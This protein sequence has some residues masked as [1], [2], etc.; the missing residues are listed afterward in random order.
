MSSVTSGNAQPT[1][2]DAT[3]ANRA[4]RLFEFLARAQEMKTARVRTF[5]GYASG[6]GSV[7]WLAEAPVHEAVIVAHRDDADDDDGR[8]V[9][10]VERVAKV[11]P[12]QPPSSLRG[13]VTSWAR[14]DDLP[15]IIHQPATR[16]PSSVDAYTTNEDVPGH[17][18][19]E[20]DLWLKSW[21]TWADQEQRDAPVRAY[22][23][24]LFSTHVQING[25]SEE[26][27]FVLGVGLLAW[28]PDQHVPVR[29]H[30]YTIPLRTEIDDSTGRLDVLID[31]AATGLTVEL[32]MLDPAVLPDRYTREK[33]EEQAE[34][35][36]RHPLERLEFRDLAAVL[37]NHIDSKGQYF[38]DSDR[39]PATGD[40]SITWAPALLVRPRRAFGLV[41]VLD[42]ISEKIED[43]GTVPEGLLPLVDPNHAPPVTTSTR[44][45][46]VLDLDGQ[47]FS[48]LPLN[49]VQRRILERVSTHAQTLVQGP[50]GTGKTHTAAALISHL[51]AQ[52]MRVLVT[53]HTDR[54]LHEVRGKLPDQV[55]PLA[56]SVIGSSRDDMADLKVAVDT[57]S[58]ESNEFEPEAARAGIAEALA[59]VDRLRQ[60]RQLLTH[61]LLRA[62]EVE[63]Q[64]H[65]HLGYEGTLAAIAQ[66][67]ESDAAS[68]GWIGGLAQPDGTSVSPLTDEEATRWLNLMRDDEV[69]AHEDESRRRLV[70]LDE[71]P[72]P[73]RFARD[74]A[75]YHE[76]SARCAAYDHLTGHP[77]R[78]AIH[79]LPA[80]TREAIQ[81]QLGELRQQ[82]D[83]LGRVR[84]Q[85][86]GDALHDVYAGQARPWLDRRQAVADRLR[87]T[88]E[89]IRFL[90]PGARVE[91]AGDP[92]PLLAMGDA[93]RAHIAS[94]GPLKVNVDG[95]PK[96]GVFASSVLKKAAPLFSQ[97]RVNG[98]PPTTPQAVDML[99]ANV[100]ASRLLDEL[101][102]A[103]PL[104]VVVPE[105][106]TLHERASWHQSQLEQLT[107]VLDLGAALR[108][109]EAHFDQ[110]GLPHPDWADLDS[111]RA[112]SDLVDAA[113]A[114]DSFD[115]VRAS[116]ESELAAVAD[117]AQ[118]ADVAAPV[119]ELHQAALLRDTEAFSAA[120]AKLIRLHEVK[121]L[122]DDR[123]QLTERIRQAAPDLVE[124]VQAPDRSSDW[125][126]RFERFDAA[127][128]W[129]S[130][131]TWILGREEID[132]N[133][134]QAKITV[135]EQ[136]LRQQAETIAATRAWTHAVSGERID[137]RARANLTQYSQLVKR[138]GKGTGKYAARQRADIREAMDRCRAAVPVWIMPIYRIAEQFKI[139]ENMF[140]VVIV[141]EASQA[142][143]EAAFLQFLAPKIV[144]IG[145]DKQ[146]SPSAVGIDQGEL[147]KLAEQYL[148]DHDH[149]AT[150]QDPKRSF[151]DEAVMR[152]GS[153][154]TLTE[155]R[156]C[157]PEIIGF[158]NRIAYE[159]DGVRLKPVRQFGADRLDPIKPVHLPRGYEETRSAR[160][161]NRAEAEALVEQIK[162]CATDPAYDG[163]TF[164]VIAL[165]GGGQVKLIESL[166]LDAI[167]PDEWGARD[168]RVGDAADFQGSERDVMFLSMVTAIGPN[169]RYT[170]LVKEDALQRFNVAAS[171]AK[172]QM[173][174]F[175][176]VGL[177]QLTNSQDLR[178]Q[179]V[180]YCYEIATRGIAKQGDSPAVP[181]DDRVAPFD[182][183]FE[184]RVYN[185]I[186]ERGYFV[187]PQYDANGYRIDL[188]VIGAH[189]RLAVECDG[190]HWHGPDAYLRDVSRQ[191]DLERCGWTFFRVR[192]S[193]YYLDQAG[194]LEGLWAMLHDLDIRP[195]GWQEVVDEPAPEELE[196][197]QP[198]VD[199][200]L[201]APQQEDEPT[202]ALDP[203]LVG[204]VLALPD[205]LDGVDEG[206]ARDADSPATGAVV[207]HLEVGQ[208]PARPNVDA[209]PE[210]RR[211]SPT[212]SGSLA[213][214]TIFDSTTTPVDETSARQLIDGLVSIVAVEGPILGERLRLSY[215][216]ASG[217]E[218]VGR[219]IAEDIDKA[220]SSA[221]RR[222]ELIADNPLKRPG[223]A[224]K[225]FRL[226]GQSWTVRELG[227]RTLAHVPPYE[228]AAVLR[229]AAA[230]R[231][232][233]SDTA[234]YRRAL[235]ILGRRQLTEQA[236][237]YLES[238][239]A[240]IDD[241][242]A[243]N[244][245]NAVGNVEEPLS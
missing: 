235:A 158:S 58:R 217:G 234:I 230:N 136:Q 191:R 68:F 74:V 35:Y 29:R 236:R 104:G 46:A 216:K 185:R 135:L 150:W 73:A 215:V 175:H 107:K 53:A 117:S 172:D 98:R 19:D 110:I 214:Y 111:V 228:A 77:A 232:H 165:L 145:D 114:S 188:V 20:Y 63:T 153:R 141:D 208:E 179:L 161:V 13:L 156:R 209:E 108:A 94:H 189:A 212:R 3:A 125:D 89:A 52:G 47:V 207:Q 67:F 112:Y 167:E 177:D 92:G 81:R 84:S 88:D 120:H 142:G 15:Q 21:R 196:T 122:V 184:Q 105:E 224:A 75:A 17:V 55:K 160:R 95:T 138:L 199:L 205:A 37:V 201:L 132:A 9:L 139:E 86:I 76:A 22:Y 2:Q 133:A 87:A 128:R 241:D 195:G 221:I 202:S 49:D 124:A 62:R 130:T 157:V 23:E 80:E 79:R 243:V 109:A 44:P 18:R 144:V 238:V 182:S 190:D 154:L 176:S 146:V 118:W 140:D 204:D 106:D 70:G 219:R 85:W 239:H 36:G 245:A 152:F 1:S 113:G 173:W 211:E 149:K 39:R 64:T 60:E 164:G 4:K 192:E 240:L 51:L 231:P 57:I 198:V 159:P 61:Q 226:P 34:A 197:A 115:G 7:L 32:D 90:G 178:R 194:S 100:A 171:R 41:Q 50:P 101:D 183:L 56:V 10:S 137:G 43:S 218:R 186:V 155:H 69:G 131:G 38:D 24:K 147:R 242:D 96:V 72:T 203:E 5:D 166:L 162:R 225:T 42:T 181:D 174:L 71:V 222:G 220:L 27:E 227:P 143:V 26:F 59:E 8:L 99:Q 206:C 30:V 237:S 168:L 193:A 213:P 170:P 169:E 40:A 151:F 65:R 119:Q 116:V 28:C 123:D 48:P 126:A 200:L 229:L 12:P 33:I 93:V 163:K 244:A 121:R 180:S 223:L 16:N 31:D 66:R 148:Y 187:E 11:D 83:A 97:V 54:A 129:A 6:A 210:A 103:W 14:A 78:D 127:W 91:V 45:G 134:A 25:R 233:L 102:H 82:I